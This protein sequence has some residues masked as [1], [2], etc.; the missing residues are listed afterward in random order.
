LLTY[1]LIG[2]AIGAITGI[3]IGP[4]NVA[5]IDAAYRHTLRRGISV[6]LGGAI[7]DFFFS[8]AAMLWIGPHVLGRPGVKP[9]LFAISGVVLMVYGVL[10]ARSQPPAA[11][12]TAPHSIPPYHEVWNG[13]TVGVGLILLNPAAIVT[14]V[15]VVGAHLNNLTTW[16]A[17]AA[18]V[19]V[20]L[21]SFAWFSFVAFIADKGKRLMGDRAVWI[22]RIVGVALVAYGLYSLARAIKYFA[23]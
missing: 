12:A 3:P 1:F 17:L 5:V 18:A 19:G 15:V 4:V 2:A 13:L 11:P 7:G 23:S 22:T 20:F 14:W 10:T 6:G 9:V 8:G 21:G 16:E